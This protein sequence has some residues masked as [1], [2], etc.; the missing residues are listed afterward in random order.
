MSPNLEETQKK[1]EAVI[2][3][4]SLREFISNSNLHEINLEIVPFAFT[5][6]AMYTTQFFFALGRR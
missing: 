6:N 1:R 3:Q 2:I 4:A 5:T